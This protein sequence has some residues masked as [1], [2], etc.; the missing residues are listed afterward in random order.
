MQALTCITPKKKCLVTSQL[1]TKYAWHEKKPLSDKNI[2]GKKNV[3]FKKQVR[4]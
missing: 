2:K 3:H 1:I 4:E